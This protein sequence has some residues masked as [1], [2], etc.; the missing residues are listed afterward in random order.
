MRAVFLAVG[1][2]FCAL[3]LLVVA[4]PPAHAHKT[5]MTQIKGAYALTAANG[6]CNACH[7]LKGGPN[8]KNLN[9]YGTAIQG[10]DGMKPLLGKKT[11]YVFT[12]DEIKAL[13][14]TLVKLDTEDADKDG[15]TNKEE[16]ALGTNPGDPDSKPAAPALEK[17]RKDNKAKDE[18]KK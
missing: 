14:K 6:K 5:F 3:M 13:L 11:D 10:E 16:L 8:R 2:L 12:Q 1:T 18:S 17:Y 9:P 4:A 15:A 7:G